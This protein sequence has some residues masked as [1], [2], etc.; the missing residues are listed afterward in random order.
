[1][2]RH[3]LDLDSFVT[4]CYL[5]FDLDHR[6][7]ELVD[8]GHT[9]LIH[10]RSETGDCEC[11]HGDN[12]PLGVRVGEVY[13]Q[14]TVPFET[15]DQF[16]LFSDGVTETR[17]R[18]GELFG[19]DRLLECVRGNLGLGPDELVEAIR[20]ATFAFSGSEAPTDDWTCVAIKVV[21]REVPLGRAELE[22]RSDL[23]ELRRVREFV[24]A[25]CH[26]LPPQSLDEAS[27]GQLELAVTEACSNIMK[28]AYRGRTDQPI[29]LEIEI[30]PG[31]VS[32][33]LHHLGDPF[34]PTKVSPPALDGSQVSGFGVYLITRSVDAARYYRDDLG[35]NC[36]AL[37]KFRKP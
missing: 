13:D 28:H 31:K 37:V 19:E 1:M 10:R 25:A 16:L 33:L 6:S 30:H 7:L 11:V 34:D 15:G 9:G 29:H 23:G 22:I 27:V 12:L 36:V 21:D 26:N 35:R 14:L 17:N 3:L 8:C 18:E 4:L 20:K 32:V 5:R 2:V 24:R